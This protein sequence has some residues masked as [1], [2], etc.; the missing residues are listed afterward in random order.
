MQILAV[1]TAQEI[2]EWLKMFT[3]LHYCTA[4][5]WYTVCLNIAWLRCAYRYLPVNYVLND[6]F[7]FNIQGVLILLILAKNILCHSRRIA[8]LNIQ[9]WSWNTYRKK[10]EKKLKILLVHWEAIAFGAGFAVVYFFSFFSSRD[11]WAPPQNFA[12][13]SEVCSIL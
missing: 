9:Y 2:T 3:F 11:L 7:M 4:C 6:V 8:L 10:R 12:R 5:M 1:H 13:C